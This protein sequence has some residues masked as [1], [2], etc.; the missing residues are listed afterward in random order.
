[1]FKI[2]YFMSMA[3]IDEFTQECVLR[4]FWKVCCWSSTS[5]SRI[6][7]ALLK[8][9]Q[10]AVPNLIDEDISEMKVQEIVKLMEE[11]GRNKDRIEKAIV[12][13]LEKL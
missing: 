8:S 11:K 1:M 12:V 2:C 9:C 3:E 13:F 10:V 7:K 6:R 4:N 5:Q